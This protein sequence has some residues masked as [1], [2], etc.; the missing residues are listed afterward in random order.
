MKFQYKFF[1]FY[2]FLWENNYLIYYIFQITQTIQRTIDFSFYNYYYYYY[3]YYSNQ[4]GHN[5]S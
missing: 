4:V 5:I 3:Y 1:I 2:I